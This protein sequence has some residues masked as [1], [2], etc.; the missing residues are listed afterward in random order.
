MCTR[1]VTVL[2]LLTAILAGTA[3]STLGYFDGPIKAANKEPVRVDRYGDPLPKRAVM[4][5]GTVRFAQPS[6]CT[7]A[8][9]PDGR[10]LA[11][12]GSDH[13]IRLWDPDVGKEVR[14]L[15]GHTSHVNSISMSADGKRLASGSQDSTLRVWDVDTGKE[16][17]RFQG[18]GY[19]VYRIA[20]SPN[21]KALACRFAGTLRLWDTDTGKVVHTWLIN[22]KY[23]VSSMAFAP[24][25][26][27]LA[28]HNREDKSVQL[29][30]VTEGKLVRTFLGHKYN[31]HSLVFSADGR[32]LIS[33]GDDGAI[34][35]WDIASGKELRRYGDEKMTVCCLALA[36]DGKTLA[37]GTID[38]LV[39]IWDIA[40]NKDLVPPWKAHR[41]RVVSIVYSPDSKRVAIAGDRIHI[42]DTATGK[43]LN[44]STE[45]ESRIQ[46]VEYAPDGKL[47]AVWRQGE[48]I[49]IW[50][51]AKWGKTTTIKAKTGRFTSMAFSPAA[52]YLTTVEGGFFD[53][54]HQAVVCHWDPQTGK[55]RKEFPQMGYLDGLSYSTDGTKLASGVLRKDAAFILWNPN[56]GNEQSRISVPPLH[57]D[58]RNPRLSPDGRLLACVTAAKNAVTVWD[59]NTGKVVRSFGKTFLGSA[60]LLTFSPDGRTV[61]TAGGNV[62]PRR[63]LEPDIVLWETATGEERLRIPKNE[64]QVRQIA[65][66]P[67][68]RMLASVGETETICFL[69]GAAIARS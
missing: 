60:H 36:P 27:K 13:Q 51:T 30:D 9:S 69:Q 66:S 29:A 24:D 40:G 12:G 17:R 11:S 53:G 38:G 46:Q 37:Y 68:G 2:A 21:G 15:E 55:R 8:F 61:A 33:A 32:T 43:R 25:S 31:V 7:L 16:L 4:R 20:L 6:P 19:P 3:P 1:T 54:A 26:K 50:E 41:F 35:L 5:L 52:E 67:D 57:G 28:F 56:T 34:R 18:D 65:F 44:P 22:E 39:H 48:T 62:D 63:A 47:L 23:G 64:G 58:V 14:I 42:Y 45:S 49:E 10:I 59:T